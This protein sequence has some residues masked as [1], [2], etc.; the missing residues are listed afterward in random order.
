[1]SSCRFPDAPREDLVTELHGQRVHDPYRWLEDC[2][3]PRTIRWTTEQ[4]I[5]Y[6]AERAAWPDLASWQAEIATLTAI[7]P[8]PTPKVRGSRYFWLRREPGQEYPVLYV[9]GRGAAR[10]L[11][12]PG[13]FDPTGRSVLDAWEPSVEGDLLACQLSR[14]GT[15]DSLLWVLDVAT[16]K[17]VDGPIERLRKSS[18]AW[19][20]GG[21]MFYYV[22]CLPGGSGSG[23]RRY[24]R[25]VYLHRIGSHRDTDLL[26]FGNGREKT[27]FYSVAVTADGRWLT[28]TATVGSSRNTDVY[29]ADLA[30]SPP[31]QPNLLPVQENV[32]AATRLHI[33]PGTGPH[34]VVWLRTDRNAARSWIAHGSPAELTTGT[35]SWR[36]L[37]RRSANV[38]LTGFAVLTGPELAR[39]VGL[40]SW[41]RHAVAEVTVHDLADGRLIARLPLPGAGTVG[42]FSVRPEGGHEAWFSYTDFTAPP[43]LLRFDA[44][45][46]ELGS[47][48]PPGSDRIRAPGVTVRS[49]RRIVR[50]R[51]GTAIRIFVV[52]PTGR[53]DRPRPAILTGY[54]G[55]G[56]TM[57]PRYRPQVLAWVHAGGLFVWACLRGGGE[58]GEPWHRAGSGRHKQNTFDDFSAVAD[59]VVAAGWTT[60]RQLA[61]M[62]GSNGGLLVGVALTQHPE[63]YA[64]AVCMSPLLDMARYEMH[65]LGPSWVPEYGTAADPAQLRTLLSY[66]PYHHVTPGTAYPPVLFTGSD[67][68]TRTHPL[69][70]RKMCAALQ[71]ASAGNRPSLFRFERGVGHGSRATSSTILLQADCLA[72][73]AR[74]L[75]LPGPQSRA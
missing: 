3:D 1:M 61:I 30:T 35:G 15:E 72:F 49:S 41:T 10:P 29:L 21:E 36:D 8:V 33:A 26:V 13:T 63:K 18:I 53:P 9:S 2:E 74:H 20:P 23:E 12:D 47:W 52:S 60:P 31:G 70:A 34:D 75:G 16:G 32:P 22:S 71:Y 7:D 44:R 28:I 66:S 37:I 45:A 64:A 40:A 4:E 5:L 65:G 55:F 38:G 11:L 54:G 24:H 27:Q 68:D 42:G 62:G 14:D 25:R 17:L 50:S 51:D 48:L 58:E 67:G 69:H 57:S 39:P 73:L 56:V 6:Q 19:L 59:F 43:Q 46:G